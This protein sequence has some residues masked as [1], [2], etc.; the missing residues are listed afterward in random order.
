M[1]VKLA[2][3]NVKRAG[4][5]YAIYFI[6]VVLGVAL[7]YAFNAIKSQTVLFDAMSADSAR[8]LDLLTLLIRMFSIVVACVLG[9]LV[10]Y[11]N[12]F[13]IR[14]RR[15][16]FGTYLLLG[17]S[18]GRVSRVLL[19]ETILVGL[20][21]L[22]VGLALGI[23]MSQ[24]L[25]FATAALMGTTMTKYRFIVSPDAIGLTVLCFVVVFMV[26]A[27][28]DVIYIRRC[29]LITLLSAREANEHVG[30]VH[31]PL[32][33]VGF[34]V[35][36]VILGCAYWQLSINGLQ[37][38]DVHFWAATV[39]MIIGTFL[40][41]WSVAGFVIFALTHA[42]GVYLKGIR[43][44]TVRQI[45]SKVNTAFVSMS[46]VCVM[47]FFALTTASVGMGLLELFAGNIE[48]TTRYDASIVASAELFYKPDP[49]W[50]DTYR[51]FNGDIEACLSSRADNWDSVVRKSAQTDFWPAGVNYQELLDQIQGAE[52][53][54]DAQTLASMGKTEIKVISESQYNACCE[55]IG[56]TGVQ[57]AANQFA[58]DNTIVGYDDLGKAM[59]KNDVSLEIAGIML[60]GYGS[61]QCVPLDTTAMSDVA[62]QIIV[63][64]EVV[65][66]LR[67]HTEFPAYTH[68][69]IM[70]NGDRTQGDSAL[71]KILAKAVPLKDGKTPLTDG[72]EDQF[73]RTPWPVTNVYTGH[74]MAEQASGLKMVIT[75]LA[76]Y[77]GFVMLVATAAVLAIQQLSETADSLQRYRRL[78]DLGCDMKQILGSLR[79][80]TIVYFCAPLVLAASHT[81][82]A[83]SVVS[84]TLFAELGVNPSGLIGISA[85]TIV[86]I[87]AVYLIVTYQ[88]SKSIVRS[89]VCQGSVL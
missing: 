16:E 19:C 13:L 88:L 2:L 63:P 72:I 21:S 26:S 14:R 8:M 6:T 25:S 58:I 69:N 39:L 82:C 71:S 43:M 86:A 42:K 65:T 66:S 31:V 74:A 53:M 79:I 20:A 70:Y 3:R 78:S 81:I 35:A 51:E 36:I 80:Q 54:K 49:S 67:E 59:S 89:S 56:E 46:V 84:A 57:L 52:A 44:F 61:L 1:L 29:K 38:A 75:F 45:A 87:Y 60:Y 17:M 22:V 15:R 10:V 32:R 37:Q 85:F 50:Q 55:L 11:A 18:A 73:Q 5:D 33:V 64:D 24:G 77:I 41:F 62:L 7:F 23:A 40:F 47:L 48:Q 4:R 12:R 34:V 9:F 68:F 27:L 83:V 28:V 30:M 76:L